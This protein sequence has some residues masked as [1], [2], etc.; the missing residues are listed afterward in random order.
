MPFI[1][2]PGFYMC[3]AGFWESEDPGKSVIGGV[4]NVT[5]LFF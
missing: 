3:T 1:I 4:L 5:L 2:S